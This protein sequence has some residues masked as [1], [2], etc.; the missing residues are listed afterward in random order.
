LLPLSWLQSRIIDNLDIQWA[1]L[2]IGGVLGE[3]GFGKVYKGMWR[4]RGVHDWRT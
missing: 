1:A 4:V 2:S 3:G